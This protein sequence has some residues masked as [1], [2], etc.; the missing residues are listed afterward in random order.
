MMNSNIDA[1]SLN[2]LFLISWNM[3]SVFHTK[4]IHEKYSLG[5]LR[6]FF[7]N[8]IQGRVFKSYVGSKGGLKPYSSRLIWKKNKSKM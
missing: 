7:K 8:P 6:S 2:D 5:P 4:G 3:T 1:I